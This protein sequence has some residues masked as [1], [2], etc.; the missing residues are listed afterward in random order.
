MAKVDC[1]VIDRGVRDAVAAYLM[2]VAHAFRIERAY[3]F[4]SRARG[5]GSPWSDI[6]LA[7]ISPDFH[8]RPWLDLNAQLHRYRWDTSTEIEPIAFT[9]DEAARASPA[10]F[11]GGVVLREGVL[12]LEHGRMVV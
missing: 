9:S 10:D 8:G 11:L 5:Q 12:V 3:L 6:D 2:R 1:H 4:G 7:L